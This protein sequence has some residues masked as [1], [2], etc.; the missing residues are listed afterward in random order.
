M[1]TTVHLCVPK[2][3]V[4]Y[5]TVTVATVASAEPA[6]SPRGTFGQLGEIGRRVTRGLWTVGNRV[7]SAVTTGEARGTPGQRHRATSRLVAPAVN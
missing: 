2:R 7:E 6:R 3:P 5:Y 1:L 4:P